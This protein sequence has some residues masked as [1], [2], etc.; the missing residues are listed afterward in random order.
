[1][2]FIFLAL[3]LKICVLPREVRIAPS[4]SSRRRRSRRKSRR[5]NNNIESSINFHEF[6]KPDTMPDPVKEALKRTD[7]K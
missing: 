5:S 3:V 6:G 2:V 4:G 7:T 1:V